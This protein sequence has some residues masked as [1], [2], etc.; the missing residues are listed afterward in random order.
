MSLSGILPVNKPEGLRSTTCVQKIRSILGRRVKTGHGGT[1]D[2]TAS[3]LLLVLVG[4]CTRLSN[5]V[6][7]LPKCYETEVTFGASTDTDDG[8]GQITARAP[9]EHITDDAIDSALCGFMGWRMQSPPAI[10]AVHVD[11]TRAHELARDGRAVI[12]QPKPVCFRRIT[13]LSSID[14]SGRVNFRVECR[15]GTY[16]RSFARD[17]G[18]RLGSRAHVSKLVRLSS[19][20]F[21]AQ[22][23]KSSDEL[24]EMPRTALAD[25][26]IS[27]DKLRKMFECYEADRASYDRLSHGQ[28][29]MLKGLKRGGG[30]SII[31]SGKVIVASDKIFSICTPSRCGGTLEL[32][33]AVNILINGGGE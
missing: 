27:F 23:A 2:S 9:W 30:T 6:M 15:K 18:E 25:E 20:P 12:P 26:F 21:S 10:S 31:S 22:M 11:G 16:I 4:Q 5:F 28:S 29:I 33:P 24:F 7:D 17:L 3:G 13:R 8:S 19:G 14:A 1:L 32:S